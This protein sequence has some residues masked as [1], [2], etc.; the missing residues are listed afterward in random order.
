MKV[1]IKKSDER[2]DSPSTAIKN[3]ERQVGQISNL[4]YESIP[5]TLT[6]DTEKNPKEIIKVVSVRR[7]K[8]L[9]DL[10]GKLDPR[11]GQAHKSN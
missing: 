3:L 11:W 7:R 10:V 9:I 5:R 4:L 2:F 1:F 6:S 8:I